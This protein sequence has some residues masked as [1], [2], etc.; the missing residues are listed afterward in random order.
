MLS[1]ERDAAAPAPAPLVEDA[2]P[3]PVSPRIDAEAWLAA[4]LAPLSMLLCD[5]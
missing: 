2:P 4:G 1:P 3:P 5:I